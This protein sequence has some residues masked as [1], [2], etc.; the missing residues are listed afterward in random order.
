MGMNIDD[1][2]YWLRKSILNINL[3][4]HLLPAYCLLIT[5]FFSLLSRN[6]APLH[7]FFLF[8]WRLSRVLSKIHKGFALSLVTNLLTLQSQSSYGLVET[9]TGEFKRKNLCQIQKCICFTFL[10]FRVHLL[11][12]QNEIQLLPRFVFY[13][14]LVWP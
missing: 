1:F 11:P 5:F 13:S 10:T 9:L 7:F 14:K 12:P 4:K 8:L 6:Q 3:K 2:Q